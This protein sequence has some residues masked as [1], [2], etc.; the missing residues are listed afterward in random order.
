[1]TLAGAGVIF[2]FGY[3]KLGEF[4]L[5]KA[6]HFSTIRLLYTKLAVYLI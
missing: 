2:Y 5:D 1:M 3:V 4:V 6:W